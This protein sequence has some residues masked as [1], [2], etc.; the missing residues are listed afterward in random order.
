MTIQVVRTPRGVPAADGKPNPLPSTPGTVFVQAVPT[1]DEYDGKRVL[2][3]WYGYEYT[4]ADI[5]A[6]TSSGGLSGGAGSTVT[7]PLLPAN[8]R[9][10]AVAHETLT[11]F[12]NS[13]STQ[14]I[15]AV[16]VGVTS[17]LADSAI[18]AGAGLVAALPLAVDFDYN[19]AVN[20]FPVKLAAAAAPLVY[21]AGANGVTYSA[22]HGILWIKII[23]YLDQ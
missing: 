4:F 15:D 6:C 8:A 5:P 10:L 19:T 17:Y 2:E 20:V 14:D 16:A 13:A 18:T 12:V 22:G 1:H 9:L 11:P 21:F 23:G 3:Y 7:F